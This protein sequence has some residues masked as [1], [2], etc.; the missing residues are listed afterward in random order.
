[1]TMALDARDP[2]QSCSEAVLDMLVHDPWLMRRVAPLL[3]DAGFADV[4]LAGHAYTTASGTDYF[5]AL[6][7]RGADALVAAGT[8]RPELAAALKEEG[9]ARIER[10]TFFGHIAY[11]SVV[12]RRP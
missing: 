6:V 1:M 9:R 4:R 7:D 2:L 3:A 8:V 10:G 11:V 5:V 12:A